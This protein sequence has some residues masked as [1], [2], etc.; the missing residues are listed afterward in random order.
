MSPVILTIILKTLVALVLALG[1]VLAL[2]L[3]FRLYLHGVGLQPDGSTIS[4][5]KGTFNLSLSLKNVGAV[6]MATSVAWGCLAYLAL[7]SYKRSAH[8]A[9]TVEEAVE[10]WEEEVHMNE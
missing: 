1:G 3:G 2:R 9:E 5:A 7:P 6:V 8:G 10:A 4:T